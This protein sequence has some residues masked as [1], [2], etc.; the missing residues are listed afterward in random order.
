MHDPWW[1]VYVLSIF[2]LGLDSK[3]VGEA[4]QPEFAEPL[5]NLTVP[6]GRDA[7]F[8]CLVQN[9][10]GYRV[11][12][13]KADTKAIQAIHVHVITNN[14]RVSVSHSGQVVWNLHIKNVQEEDRGQYMCQINTDPMKSQVSVVG[15]SLCLLFYG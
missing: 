9:L 14:H 3:L 13:V 7:T 15:H 4:F 2:M 8:Q 11:G 5:V 10:G 12:W 1:A 6:R